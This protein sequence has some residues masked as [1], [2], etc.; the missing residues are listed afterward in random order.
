MLFQHVFI[1]FAGIEKFQHCL[2]S[3]GFEV[4]NCDFSLEFLFF[5][6]KN[7]FSKF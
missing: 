3:F 6:F 2:N 4:D 1:N 5:I 7:I